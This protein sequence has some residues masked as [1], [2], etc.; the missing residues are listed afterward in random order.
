MSLVFSG[1]QP[2]GIIH[3]GN[4]LGTLK[5][6]VELGREHDCIFC[7]VD[8]HAITVDYEPNGLASRTLDVAATLMAIGIDPKK[9]LLFVQSQVPEHAYLAWIFNTL[10]PIGELERMTQFKD[11]AAENRHNINAGLLAYPVLQAA[12]I[13]LYKANEVPVGEDQVQHLELARTIARKFNRKF[14]ET[15]PEPQE[16]LGMGARI[17]SLQE[18]IKKMSKSSGALHYIALSDDPETISKK[19]QKAVT[20]SRDEIKQGPDKPALTNLLTIHSLFSGKTVEEIEKEF[21]GKGYGEYKKALSEDIIAVLAPIR[22]K[23]NELLADKNKLVSILK[24]GDERARKIA[25]K[26][27]EEVRQ[28]TGL[29]L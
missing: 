27:I 29:R 2:S 28:K 4:Y 12:D 25:Q 22:E 14:G 10:S 8:L 7:I 20:D 13:L 16:K 5:N 6:W 21:L 24:E 15:F 18:P 23:R 3:I 11:K 26:T 17:M 19:I 1:I 9:C